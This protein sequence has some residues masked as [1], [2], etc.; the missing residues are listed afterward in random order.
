V[1]FAEAVWQRIDQ[2]DEV[3]DVSI[4]CA[5]PDAEHKVYALEPVG[6]SLSMPMSMPHVLVTP[7]PPVRTRRADLPSVLDR[8]E[9][10]LHRAFELERAVHPR[11]EDRRG[12]SW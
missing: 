2:R 3:R 4:T 8:L 9:A 7:D 1:T 12:G 11:A 6:S 5:V 10:E